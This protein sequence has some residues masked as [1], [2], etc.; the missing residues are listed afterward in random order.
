KQPVKA[1][2]GRIRRIEQR[3][4]LLS[5]IDTTVRELV[6][7]PAFVGVLTTAVVLSLV[8]G[9]SIILGRS[10]LGIALDRISDRTFTVRAPFEQIDETRTQRNREIAI[11]GTPRVFLADHTAISA[12]EADL[13]G[14][15]RIVSEAG[16]FEEVP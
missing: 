3:P 2:P 5:R 11:A 16:S 1:R 12:L 8:L 15:P 6:T 4:S 14:L 10:V 13:R 7:H 9:A